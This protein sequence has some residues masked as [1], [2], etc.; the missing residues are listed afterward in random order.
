VLLTVTQR[1]LSDRDEMCSVAGGWHTHLDILLDNLHGR[2]P[3]AFWSAH[4]KVE[5]EYEQSLPREKA[6][7]RVSRDFA[8]P[9]ERVFDAWVEPDMVSKWLFKTP[10][11]TIVRA[12]ID[13][14]AGG[15][16][17]IVDRREDGDVEHRG[18]YLEFD[19]P[20]RLVFTVQVPKYSEEVDC[21]VIDIVPTSTGCNL[22]LTHEL[23]PEW[24]DQTQQGWATL[25]DALAQ[26]LRV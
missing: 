3:R 13:A 17:S 18:A 7:V 23:A 21:V 4:T 19:R 12:D 14:R 15:S 26:V 25:L 22:V 10:S 16:Y 8:A 1:R 2:T 9:A 6:I 11:G 20:R 5:R 24:V